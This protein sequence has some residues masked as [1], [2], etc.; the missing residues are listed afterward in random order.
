MLQNSQTQQHSNTHF[1][2]SGESFAVLDHEI[3]V[4]EGA[5]HH[6]G[7]GIRRPGR[8]T[9][10]G[11]ATS[12]DIEDM[13]R[14][15]GQPLVKVLRVGWRHH[16]V[17]RTVNDQHR[18]GYLGQQFAQN[19]ELLWVGPDDSVGCDSGVLISSSAKS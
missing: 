18:S 11:V 13:Q 17:S 5:G 6:R 3:D 8:R 12:F 1:T 9:F 10:Y 19:R 16:G 15:L 14:A 7:T 2:A 4:M